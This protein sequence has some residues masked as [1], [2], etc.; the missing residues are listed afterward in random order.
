MELYKLIKSPIGK[1]LLVSDG[2]NLTGLYTEQQIKNKF[3]ALPASVGAKSDDLEIF[4]VTEKQLK[5]YFSGMR[6]EFSIPLKPQGSDFQKMVWEE[7]RRIA[8]ATTISYAELAKRLGNP[9][10][11]RAVGNANSKNPI[12]IIVPCHR[13]IGANG[14]LTGYAGGIECKK[15][16]LHHEMKSSLASSLKAEAVHGTALTQFTKS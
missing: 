14:A 7:L 5:E 1:L 16:L 9:S 15:E 10:A 8:F 6:T 12:S 11:S 13:V 4:Q 3:N 2:T